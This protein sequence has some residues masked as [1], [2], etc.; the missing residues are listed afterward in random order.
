VSVASGRQGPTGM[1]QLGLHAAGN[2]RTN[3]QLSR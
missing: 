2:L 1:Q 3:G